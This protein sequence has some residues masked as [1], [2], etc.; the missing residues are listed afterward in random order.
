[1]F[2]IAETILQALVA[3]ILIGAIYGLMCVGLALIFGVMKVVNFAQGEF[4][5]LGMYGAL[6][7][8][9]VLGVYATASPAI[10][11]V[12]AALVAGVA[13]GIVGLLIHRLLL[14]H[15]T[16]GTS[17]IDM[18]GSQ[19][20]LTLGISLV[21]Q[22]GALIL[23]GSDIRSVR[24]PLSSSA[25]EISLFG[26]DIALFVNQA[27]LVGFVITLVIV[28][29][30]HLTMT[31]TVWGKMMRAAADNERAA[32]Y[33]GIDVGR[34]HRF[35]FALGVAIAA[36]AGGMLAII[37]SFQPYVGLD[38]VVTM[39]AGVVLGG[40]GSV[41]GAFWGGMVIGIVQQ[42]STLFLPAQ[43]QNATIFVVFLL[44]LIFRPMGIFGR[45]S[46]RT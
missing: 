25:L 40:L 15:V 3:G 34:A 28:G 31:K 5:T 46:E 11:S 35:A 24:T 45:S 38:F 44:V 29:V 4:L 26:G 6:A 7:V 16:G 23:L 32:Q 33:M 37:Q 17:G 18:H 27:R 2:A 30:I 10:A 43:L 1:M 8:F 13:V 41:I 42:V 9:A 21:I 19:L 20:V 14:S 39:Y 12:I 36:V 22:N